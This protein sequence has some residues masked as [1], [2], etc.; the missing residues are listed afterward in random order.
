MRL[1][2]CDRLTQSYCLFIGI[3]IVYQNIMIVFS[4]ALLDELDNDVV[5]D[6]LAAEAGLDELL[7]LFGYL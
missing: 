5:R 7:R 6:R 1:D 3:G 4:D 2:I